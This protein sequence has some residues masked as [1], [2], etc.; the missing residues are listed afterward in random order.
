MGGIFSSPRPPAPD[1]SIAASQAAQ[2]AR[3]EKQ[4]KRTEQRE[5]AENRRLSSQRRARRTGGLNLLLADRP[6]AQTGIQDDELQ[7]TLGNSLT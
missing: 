4:E 1:P 3:I 2:E 5:T 6:N 7:T